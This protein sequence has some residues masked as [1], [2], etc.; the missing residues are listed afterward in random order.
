M[1]TAAEVALVDL[2]PHL[3]DVAVLLGN[4]PP[5]TVAEA[6]KNSKRLDQDFLPHCLS[7][8]RSGVSVLAAPDTYDPSVE[9]ENR[10]GRKTRW[11][12][13]ET[14]IRTW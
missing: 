5:F 3:G 10:S 1:E 2:N 4:S 12:S 13:S 11:T 6:L 9:I 14:S 7:R 8:H